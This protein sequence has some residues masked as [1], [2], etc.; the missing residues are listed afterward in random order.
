VT[1]TVVLRLPGCRPE[2][3]AQYLKALGVLR[4]VA[5]QADPGARGSWSGEAFELRSRLDRTQL[6]E[7]LL[8]EYVPTPILDPWNKDFWEGDVWAVS[9]KPE[10]ETKPKEVI[11][12]I[13]ER[14]EAEARFD[15]YKRA[16]EAAETARRRLVQGAHGK[17][18]PKV[19]RQCLLLEC[20]ATLPDEFVDWLDAVA[21]LGRDEVSYPRWLGRGGNDGRTEL[22]VRFA[23]AL[24]EALPAPAVRKRR[25]D[26]DARDVL[27]AALFADVRAK[28]RPLKIGLL[29][30]GQAGGAN[31]GPLG[32]AGASANPWDVVLALEGAICFASGAARRMSGG[33]SVPAVPFLVTGT[34]AGYSTSATGEEAYEIWTPLWS[35]PASVGEV[36]RLIG[37]GRCAVGTRMAASGLELAE[38][39]AG[40]GVDRGVDGFVRHAV[41]PRFG[42]RYHLVVPLERLSV[43]ER[44]AVRLLGAVDDWVRPLRQSTGKTSGPKL[45]PAAAAALGA[46]DRAEMEVARGGGV[47]SL[48][49]VLIAVA[50]LETAV[51]LV[52][53]L[54]GSPQGGPVFRQ[55]VAPLRAA[56]WL[57]EL[58]DGSAEVRLAAALASAR[59]PQSKTYAYGWELGVLA[60]LLRPVALGRGGRLVWGEASGAQVVLARRSLA[61]ALSEAA[62]LRTRFRLEADH[63]NFD[64]GD[65][66]ALV[67]VDVSLRKGIFARLGDLGAF[68]RGEL[69]EA[70]LGRL[71]QA[72]LLLDWRGCQDPWSK[73]S[74]P[75][76]QREGSVADVL[77]PPF[78]LV[79]PFAQALRPGS[80]RPR[81]L[82]GADW[83][84][85]LAAGAVEA[86]V[87]DGIRRLR[88]ASLVPL[89]LAPAVV[90]RGIDGERLASTM[91]VR[92]L[93][94]DTR[95]LLGR[96]ALDR[97][98]WDRRNTLDKQED[99]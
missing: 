91:L 88:Y 29:D 63:G 9:S 65:E 20:R 14:A 54:V 67:G 90:A 53:S 36:R 55:P 95:R 31:S 16:V 38:A 82:P 37:E 98:Q 4:L 92:L 34:P 73:V 50:Q 13:V 71:L 77:P 44:P 46:L 12:A 26:K 93:P 32:D 39:V 25:S 23:E 40:L 66:P 2:P 10:K 48:Q 79:A 70:R 28:S 52:S 1:E 97:E 99:T 47:E 58:D 85:Q 62:T 11:R 27:Q 24:D 6:V 35:A 18:K 45:S 69:D 74:W 96:V 30:P 5:E 83:A 59:D 22:S 49:E 78:A 89:L 15:L 8:C 60:W 21:V 7:F 33:P 17:Q 61:T 94:Q 41:V 76:D 64:D 72:M 86:V 57:V 87:V 19:L 68:F 42:D 51:A 43:V 56:D 81:L 3:I 80:S 84:P 75:K